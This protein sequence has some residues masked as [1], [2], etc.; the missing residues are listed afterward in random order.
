MYCERCSSKMEIGIAIDPGYPENA[1]T[2]F[3]PLK[4]SDTIDIIDVFK[5][6]KCGHSEHIDFAAV[7]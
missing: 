6:P 2:Q 4:N 5:C 7:I 1:I 3:T